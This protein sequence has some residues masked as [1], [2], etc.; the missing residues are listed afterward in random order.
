M[1][2]AQVKGIIGKIRGGTK[3]EFCPRFS[4]CFEELT[5]EDPMRRYIK[6]AKHIKSEFL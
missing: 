1:C 5:I 2:L 3:P 6:C 4:T